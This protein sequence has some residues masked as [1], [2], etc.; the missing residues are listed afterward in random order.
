MPHGVHKPGYFKEY[1]KRPEVRERIRIYERIRNKSPERK[2]LRRKK[3][4]QALKFI[5]NFKI[6]KSCV[7]CGWK[8][9]TEILNFHHKNPKEKKISLSGG[10]IGSLSKEKILMEIKKCDL[11]CPNCH[12]WL[13]YQETAK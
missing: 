12:M 8:K 9:H 2:E 7:E 3:R 6:N 13:H 11:L 10:N 5:R 1:Y 4:K